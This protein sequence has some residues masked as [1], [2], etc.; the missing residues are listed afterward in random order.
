MALKRVMIAIDDSPIAAHAAEFGVELAR[1]ANAEIA[2]IHAA[3]VP[4]GAMDVPIAELM[5]S[6]ISEGKQLIKRTRDVLKLPDSTAEFVVQGAASAEITKAAKDWRADLIVIGSHG[7]RGISRA[8]LGSVAE[9]VMRH[10][11]CP[12][13][14]VKA[15]G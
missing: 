1:S 8:L 3:E 6:L 2:L 9:A 11:P 15:A 10:A 4:P 13:L 12:V 14:T 5:Q 7:R